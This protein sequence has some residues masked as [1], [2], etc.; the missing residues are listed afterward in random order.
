MQQE[1]MVNLVVE[2]VRLEMQE[3]T[4]AIGATTPLQE[5]K[6]FDSLLVANLLE[7]LE[8]HLGFEM[9]PALILPET[10]VSPLTIA[11][12]LMQSQLRVQNDVPSRQIGMVP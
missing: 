1:A 6:G 12:A 3:T 9:D 5:L 2:A 7:R 10:F 4:G 8:S 11:E